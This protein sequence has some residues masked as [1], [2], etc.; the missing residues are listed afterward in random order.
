MILHP[1]QEASVRHSSFKHQF[2]EAEKMVV[3]G[4]KVKEHGD[5]DSFAW[6]WCG[7]L[8]YITMVGGETQR[9]CWDTYHSVRVFI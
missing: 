8:S 7:P 9:H 1:G 3:S 4:P 6:V 2:K 5:V